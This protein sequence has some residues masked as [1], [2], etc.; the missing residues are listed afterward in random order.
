MLGDLVEEYETEH[1]LIPPV[2]DADMPRHLIEARGTTQ[3]AVAAESGIAVSTISEILAGK[4]GP[5]RRHIEALA[6]MFHVSPAV[7]LGS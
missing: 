3:A 5:N 4:R 2:S 1:H 6:R 7:F